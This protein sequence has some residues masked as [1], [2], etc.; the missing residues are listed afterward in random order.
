MRFILGL[1]YRHLKDYE[2][3]ERFFNNALACLQPDINSITD[4]YLHLIDNYRLTDSF[5]KMT[6]AYLSALV[7]DDDNPFLHYGLAYT[8]DHYLDDQEKAFISY[9]RFKRI[10][11]A[12]ADNVN[13]MQMLLDH[14]EA[15]IRRI[16]EDVFFGNQ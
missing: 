14:A 9:T 12:N 5:N 8:L 2:I 4:T 7:Y 1:I 3:S 15:R 16:K 10:V 11:S 6:D 13:E